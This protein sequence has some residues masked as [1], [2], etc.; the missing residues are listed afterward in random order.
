MANI[1]AAP[2]RATIIK[3]S[4]D[5]SCRDHFCIFCVS[6]GTEFLAPLIALRPVDAFLSVLSMREPL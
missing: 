6:Q 1:N 2:H 3:V 5:E 4:L